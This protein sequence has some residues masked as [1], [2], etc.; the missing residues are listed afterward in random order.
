[1]DHL[2]KTF[3]SFSVDDLSRAQKFYAEVTGLKTEQNSMGLRLQLPG[4]GTVFL[5]PKK[6]HR[7]ASFTV[8]N[9]V[10]GNLNEAMAQLKSRGVEFEYY[11]GLTD[12]DRVLRGIAQNKGPDIAWF[13]D[14]A[15]NILSVL[16]EAG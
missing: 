11:K 2:H 16:Q 6:D 8:L 1:M 3:S 13:K 9:F 14:P 10:V 12:E 4:G 15:G 7:P 5:Y